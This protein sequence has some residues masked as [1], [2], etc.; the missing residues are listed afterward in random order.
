VQEQRNLDLHKNT[1]VASS[2]HCERFFTPLRHTDLAEFQYRGI[3]K[4]EK[5]R[6]VRLK[7][8]LQVVGGDVLEQSVVEYFQ[9]AGT[10]LTGV[11]KAVEGM[12]AG[13]KKEGVIPAREA[14]GNPAGQP[15]KTLPRSEFPK[16]AKLEKGTE[17][18]AKAENGQDVVL[19]V[20]E[21][22][23]KEVVVRLVHGLAKKDI[24]YQVEVLSVTDPT[25]PPLP[26]SAVV[27]EEEEA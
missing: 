9:G 8:R 16:D 2:C 1:G 4:I 13:E 11:E 5:G 3:V 12:A 23:E 10:M 27:E 26:A 19:L 15:R 24:S 18:A 22:R 7:V 17:F 25:P 21:A 6:R 14:F 20:E